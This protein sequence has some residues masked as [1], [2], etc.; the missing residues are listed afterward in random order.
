M[1]L[2]LQFLILHTFILQFP[3]T[4]RQHQSWRARAIGK[5]CKEKNKAKKYNFYGALPQWRPLNLFITTKEALQAHKSKSSTTK[6]LINVFISVTQKLLIKEKKSA[7]YF[8]AYISF[9]QKNK[10][11][12][13]LYGYIENVI[14]YT[15]GE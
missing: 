14:M 7:K 11:V 4:F 2:Q 12:N 8:T 15:F 10:Q 5:L 13:K 1:Q 3:S 6:Y 9:V